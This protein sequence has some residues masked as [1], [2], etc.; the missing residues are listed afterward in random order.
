MDSRQ[1]RGRTLARDRRTRQIEGSTWYVPSQNQPGAGYLV[2]AETGACACLDAQRGVKCK[3]VFAVEYRRSG[4]ITP[5]GAGTELATVPPGQDPRDGP[6]ERRRGRRG[7]LSPEEQRHV[8]TALRYLRAR[9]GG[10]GPL[11]KALRYRPRSLTR[12]TPL[13]A[14]LVFRLA[15][16]AEV[17]V[18]DVLTGRYPPGGACPRCGY[19]PETPSPTSPTTAR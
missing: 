13:S 18:D 11:A 16:L 15:R 12:G 19:L 6:Q 8:K 2:N 1:E 7:D 14:K 17:P 3:H 4:E 9:L 10:W 5:E